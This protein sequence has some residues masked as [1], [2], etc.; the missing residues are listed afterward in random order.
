MEPDQYVF[1]Q[2]ASN[3]LLLIPEKPTCI[4]K[5]SVINF[6]RRPA[7]PL[8]Q[9]NTTT[10]NQFSN[11][12]FN[13]AT[14]QLLHH[15]AFLALTALTQA[16]VNGPC[17][18][19]GDPNGICISTSECASYGGSSDPGV[20]GA[21]TCPGTPNDVQCCSILNNCLGFDTDTLCTWNNECS[22]SPWYGTILPSK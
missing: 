13:L 8:I 6:I 15:L 21:Y 2:D 16:S 22:G 12:R 19:G 20:P 14:M 4:A 18:N 17:S 3:K 1:S 7:L 9:Y 10:D 5:M 11:T